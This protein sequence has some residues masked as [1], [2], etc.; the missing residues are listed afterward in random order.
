MESGP[1]CSLGDYS[2]LS[3]PAKRRQIQGGYDEHPA[4]AASSDAGFVLFDGRELD[5]IQD[6]RGLV[7]DPAKTRL[8]GLGPAA[9]S[10]RVGLGLA[11]RHRDVAPTHPHLV[12]RRA[13]RN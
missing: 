4:M 3:K 13:R 1:F 5:A 12:D 10:V 6:P 2:G 7:E 11:W 8:D 9:D